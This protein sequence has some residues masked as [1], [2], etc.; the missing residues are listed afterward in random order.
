MEKEYRVMGL[1]KHDGTWY[2][3][4][5]WT[6]ANYG[7][8]RRAARFVLEHRPDDLSETKVEVREVSNWADFDS[9]KMERIKMVKAMEYLA[10]AVNDEIVFDGWLMNG[11]ADGDIEEG[12][13]TIDGG[14]VEWYTDDDN[15]ADLMDTF[16]R[17]MAR[18]KKSGGLYCDG[19]VSKGW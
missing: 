16:L 13:L 15:F 3:V 9:K 12:D 17:L 10:R 5:A 8:A 14:E 11:A 18:A 1:S 2:Q 19:I 7:N 6:H 4:E